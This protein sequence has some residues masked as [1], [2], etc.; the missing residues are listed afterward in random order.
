MSA[1]FFNKLKAGIR[2]ADQSITGP[3]YRYQDFI[4][5]TSE[6]GIN[7]KGTLAQLGKN[8]KGMI[9]YTTLLH[10]GTGSNLIGG[11]LGNSFFLKT[12]GKCV[13]ARRGGRYCNKDRP[14]PDG[15]TCHYN[16]CWVPQRQGLKA[17]RY[18]YFDNRTKGKLPFIRGTTGFKGLVPGMLENIAD[19]N[20]LEVLTAFGQEAM[21]LCK[22]HYG[23][24]KE[25]YTKGSRGQDLGYRNSYRRHYVALS[26]FPEGFTNRLDLKNKPLLN[27][28][29]T[30][31]GVLL[32]YI[33]YCLMEKHN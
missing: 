27:T 19:M 32:I 17:D 7:N 2:Y 29:T 18:I 6:A 13:P 1:A 15:T 20:P 24:H 26:D 30:G 5:N 9:D 11:P 25:S 23:L 31:F 16:R 8:I 21:P 12:A 14:C 3:D 33:L 28:Y 4:K 10:R 22:Q